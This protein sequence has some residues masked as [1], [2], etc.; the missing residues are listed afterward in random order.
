MTSYVFEGTEVRKT[1]RKAQRKVPQPGKERI[2]EVYE[3]TPVGDDFDWKKW[4]RPEEL[5]EIVENQE[6]PDA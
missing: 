1:G 2:F 5:Y 4:V 3:I 6:P